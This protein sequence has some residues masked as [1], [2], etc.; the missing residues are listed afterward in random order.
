MKRH[1]YA[2]LRNIPW[3]GKYS[4]L[5][6]DYRAPFITFLRYLLITS[7]SFLGYLEELNTGQR[8][9]SLTDAIISH[10]FVQEQHPLKQCPINGH[11][12]ANREKMALKKNNNIPMLSFLWYKNPCY[13]V[14]SRYTKGNLRPITNCKIPAQIKKV[15][16][17]MWMINQ[18]KTSL[19]VTKKP[20]K[21]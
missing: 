6:M 9:R 8:P 10:H 5:R 11:I 17:E 18:I 4:S 12:C 3:R 21:T 15:P 14:F 16:I 20:A 13:C 1:I 7:V 2:L 19:K